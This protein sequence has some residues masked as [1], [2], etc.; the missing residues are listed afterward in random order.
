MT[1]VAA[2][3]SQTADAASAPTAQLLTDD[4]LFET[5]K[6]LKTFLPLLKKNPSLT[7]PLMWDESQ[8]KILMEL[9]EVRGFLKQMQFVH[10]YV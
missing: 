6:S 7:E 3:W 5:F 1:M 4:F 10:Y 2:V 9:K 8:R